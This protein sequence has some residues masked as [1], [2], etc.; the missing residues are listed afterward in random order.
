MASNDLEDLVAEWCA[1][2]GYYVRQNVQVGKRAAGGK[3]LL[4]QDFMEQLLRELRGRKFRSA[5]VPES[6]PL[7]H[8]LQFAA[9]WWPVSIS[10]PQA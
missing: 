3:V 2:G 9:Q 1:F 4:I 6:F 8:T 10:P 7:L 5:A